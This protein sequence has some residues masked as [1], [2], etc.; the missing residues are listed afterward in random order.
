MPT[1]WGVETIEKWSAMELKNGTG[2]QKHPEDSF[3]DLFL[4]ELSQS[5]FQ[6]GVSVCLA[7]FDEQS[8]CRER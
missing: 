1:V 8:S 5:I 2:I 6:E 7:P 4:M 3:I